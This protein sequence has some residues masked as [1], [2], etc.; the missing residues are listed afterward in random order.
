MRSLIAFFL[1][2]GLSTSAFAA[3]VGDG[4]DYKIDLDGQYI[5]K[6]YE[7]PTPTPNW[8]DKLLSN[9]HLEFGVSSWSPSN[10]QLGTRAAVTSPFQTDG[11]PNLN[12]AFTSAPIVQGKAGAL[13]I[14]AGLGLSSLQRTGS[15][16]DDSSSM[17][18]GLLMIPLEVGVQYQPSF[19]VWRN[20]SGYVA[21]SAMPTLALT[22]RSI[23]DDGTT[24][25]GIA[26]KTLLGVQADLSRWTGQIHAALDVNFNVTAGSVSG[27]SLYGTGIGAG[28]QIGI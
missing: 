10:L 17:T 28:V 7:A 13:M 16:T 15:A 24:S 14:R 20:F 8:E 4:G 21:E 11:L 25:L 27:G 12:F 26:S 23:Y 22:E 18:Q 3:D 2:A 6:S 19:L 9:A 5:H 1:I